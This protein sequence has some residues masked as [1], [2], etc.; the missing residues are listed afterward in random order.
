MLRVLSH[1]VAADSLRPRGLQHTRLL[2]LWNF[3]ARILGWVPISTPGDLADL[4]IE[5]TSLAMGGG[6]F[7]EK[8]V[9]IV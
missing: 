9:E 5:P 7:T 2:C 4:G 3:P 8:P 1:A 6:F